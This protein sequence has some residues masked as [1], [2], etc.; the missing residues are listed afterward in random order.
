MWLECSKNDRMIIEQWEEYSN[1]VCLL[2][3]IRFPHGLHSL[4]ETINIYRTS[5][6]FLFFFLF[7]FCKIST[8]M[9]KSSYANEDSLQKTTRHINCVNHFWFIVLFISLLLVLWP[10]IHRN[11]DCAQSEFWVGKISEECLIILINY[12]KNITRFRVSRVF[13]LKEIKFTDL[14]EHKKILK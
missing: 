5:D 2:E 1:W 11:H 10:A 8:Q 6:N 3:V 12:K 4:F 14:I 13:F 7:L 9:R